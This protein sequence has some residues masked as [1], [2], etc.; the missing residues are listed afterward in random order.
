MSVADRDCYAIYLYIAY[1]Y[2]CSLSHDPALMRMFVVKR[3]SHPPP[4]PYAGASA[5]SS[6]SSANTAFPLSSLGIGL[7]SE[8]ANGSSSSKAGASSSSASSSSDAA[9]AGTMAPSV[10][11]CQSL[12]FW[13]IRRLTTDPDSGVLVQ[14]AEILRLCLDVDSMEGQPDRDSFL[15]AFYDHHI[16]WLVEPFCAGADQSAEQSAEQ[17]ADQAAHA[18]A[19]VSAAG[20]ASRAHVCDLLSFCVRS[21][22]YRMKYFVLRNHIVTR[23]LRLVRCR[24]KFL[25]VRPTAVDVHY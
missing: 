13:V 6:S 9:G 2:C 1:C 10:E 19:G 3:G 20:K 21:H 7:P 24:D 16:H 18:L 22:T 4:P 8:R 15:G 14:A 11:A 23:V 25:Q 5:T 17:S 12:L